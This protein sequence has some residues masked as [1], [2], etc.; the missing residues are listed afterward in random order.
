MVVTIGSNPCTAVNVLN[1][2]ELTCVLPAGAGFNQLVVA[3]IGARFSKPVALLWYAPPRI[4]AVAG[5]SPGQDG[6]TY[7][8]PRNVRCCSV[9]NTV[10]SIGFTQGN[11]KIT[12]AGTNFV[13]SA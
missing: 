13:R 9:R 12:I 4:A 5:C 7:D 10:C 6:T 2:T 1:T 11:T 3:G 8:C